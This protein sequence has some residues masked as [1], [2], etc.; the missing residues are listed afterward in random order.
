MS[1]TERV[2]DLALDLKAFFKSEDL[3][4]IENL[5]LH[6]K[7]DLALE[8]LC[9]QLT[10]YHSHIPEKQF[11][12][13]Q[14]LTQE[15]NLEPEFTWQGLIFIDAETKTLNRLFNENSKYVNIA[16]VIGSVVDDIEQYLKS[17][18]TALIR[19]FLSANEPELAVDN[20]FGV[21]E[22]RTILFSKQ[23]YEKLK[24]VAR[25]FR[26]GEKYCERFAI[27]D[28]DATESDV[29]TDASYETSLPAINEK[30]MD[31]ITDPK[32]PWQQIT[33]QGQSWYNRTKYFADGFRDGKWIRVVFE[34]NFR[35][36]LATYPLDVRDGEMYSHPPITA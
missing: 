26:L 22:E 10:N 15:M 30:W 7:P 33:G 35:G 3:K 28:G 34:D 32:V 19:E 1:I 25:H 21:L 27:R 13:I 17:Q 4:A 5:L 20:L 23:T 2:R 31:I 24:K 12:E 36:I 16:L 29:E 6:E 14:N 8:A 11:R 9:D 18:E